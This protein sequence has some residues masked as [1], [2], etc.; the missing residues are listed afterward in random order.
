M[1]SRPALS[2][3]TPATGVASPER[4]AHVTG[5][6]VDLGPYTSAEWLSRR[7]AQFG[8]CQTYA[9]EVWHFELHPDAPEAGCPAPY[10]DASAGSRS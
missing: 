6:A 10:A 7:G 5:D 1:H 2:R 3:P 8:L 9:N 4:S